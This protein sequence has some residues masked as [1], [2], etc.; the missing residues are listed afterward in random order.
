MFEFPHHATVSVISI[1][2]LYNR[3]LVILR[4]VD[5]PFVLNRRL[6]FNFLAVFICSLIT[7]V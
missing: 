6:D 5:L 2:L 1:R 3:R 7:E 4:L